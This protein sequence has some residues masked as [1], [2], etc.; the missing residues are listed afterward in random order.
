MRDKMKNIVFFDLETDTQGKKVLDIGATNNRDGQFH[1][2]DM[3]G[4]AKFLQDA[5]YL[6]GHNVFEHDFKYVKS[7]ILKSPVRKFIDTHYLSPLL[8]PL[9]PHHDIWKEY[10]IISKDEQN[11]PYLDS[12]LARRLLEEEISIF[13][14]LDDDLKSIYYALLYDKRE[15][16]DFFKYVDFTS[17]CNCVELIKE[18]FKDRICGNAD[19]AKYL[20]DNPIELAYSLALINTTGNRFVTPY[21]VSWKFPK[22]EN[23]IYELRNR[24][25]IEGCS[26]CNSVINPLKALNKYFHYENFR[27]Y[28]GEPGS[29][30]HHT[31]PTI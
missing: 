5:E 27:S 7:A 12:V 13:N 19:V 17:E 20:A 28:E 25:C 18:Y 16:R 4:F 11:N 15:F 14:K 9:K 6:C 31:L 30:T 23:I 8:F 21:W 1:S 10:K 24:R 22:I 29:Y 3:I 26:Y 2:N